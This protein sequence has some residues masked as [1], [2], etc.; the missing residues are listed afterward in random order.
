MA[1][2]QAQARY[3]YQD[4]Q[5]MINN[6]MNDVHPTVLTCLMRRRMT[7]VNQYV[8][9]RGKEAVSSEYIESHTNA[10]KVSVCVYEEST[11]PKSTPIRHETDQWIRK[12]GKWFIPRTK[13]EGII[14]KLQKLNIVQSDSGANRI[15]TDDLTLLDNIQFIH[16]YPMGG[17]NKDNVAITCTAKG[18]MKLADTDGSIIRVTAYYSKE[19]DGTIVSPTAIIR[20]HSDK[21]SSFIQYS[22]CDN[23]SGNIRLVARH[24]HDDFI[25]RLTCNNDL[26][27]HILPSSTT[28]DK[29]RINKMSAAAQYELWHQRTGHAGHTV[30][31]NL[32]KHA[33]GV[34]LLKGNAFYKCPSCM[35]GKL[36]TKRPYKKTSVQKHSKE[37]EEHGDDMDIIHGQPGQH[38]HIDFGFVRG[39]KPTTPTNSTHASK[40]HGKIVTSIDGY[41]CYVIVVDRI[42]RYTWI[43]LSKSK[44]PPIETIR[45]LLNKF[46]SD[47][48]HRTVRTDQGG[49]LGHSTE[50]AAMIAACGYSL[51]ETGADASSQNGIAER[52]NRTYGQMMRCMLSSAEL[53]PE[54]WSFALL[55][56]VYVRNRL[57]HATIKTSPYE[58]MT[59]TKPNLS[60]LR[61]FGCRMFAKKPGKRTTKL[62]HHTYTGIFLGFTATP[63][64]ARYIDEATGTIKVASNIIYDEACMT[65]NAKDI[66]LSA[67]TLQILGYEN[68]SSVE[69]PSPTNSTLRICKLHNEAIVPTKAMEQS[70]GYDL[71]ANIPQPINIKPGDII[72]IPTGIAMAPPQGTYIRIAPRSGLTCNK[73]LT[74]MAGVVDPDYRGDIKIIIHNFGHEMQTIDPHSKIAQAILEKVDYPIVQLV[75]SLD[76]TTRGNKGFG[77][78]DTNKIPTASIQNIDYGDNGSSKVAT[79][80]VIPAYFDQHTHLYLSNDVYDN[81]TS[82]IVTI[83]PKDNNML[84]MKLQQCTV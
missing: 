27:Y 45:N 52:P 79:M 69:Q 72:T 2:K 20:Q 4:L 64:N 57:W 73:H 77:S 8:F 1:I 55:H 36:C 29:C 3:W 81:T 51:E 40:Q 42:T 41:T 50:F 71:Y 7:E 67:R 54:F 24:G 78:S 58:R 70:V 31:R 62:D 18:I 76:E 66:P 75:D 13:N 9:D 22:N 84:G 14:S 59:G 37:E 28:E 61:I 65:L 35:T 74:T 82:R 11:V 53:G 43:F 15:V 49:E 26:W 38:Y 63:K 44:K 30:L 33:E 23:N 68:E 60:T 12:H 5:S 39:Q 34:P 80:T 19:V 16:D 46:K 83:K 47:D 25:M 32:N 48:P 17:C 56:A 6:L 10:S 21:F